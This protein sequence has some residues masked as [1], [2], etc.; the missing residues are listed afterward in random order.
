MERIVIENV[1]EDSSGRSREL[2]QRNL[3]YKY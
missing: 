1:G 3:N 2:L